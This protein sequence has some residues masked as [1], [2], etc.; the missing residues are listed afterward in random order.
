MYINLCVYTYIYKRE[1]FSSPPS[2]QSVTIRILYPYHPP[3]TIP[4]SRCPSSL[5]PLTTY[6][7]SAA[8]PTKSSSRRFGV[9]VSSPPLPQESFPSTP[10]CSSYFVCAHP[11]RSPP[12]KAPPTVTPP[13]LV[14][15]MLLF[16]VPLPTTRPTPQALSIDLHIYIYIHACM[17]ILY[18]YIL[19][20][21]VVSSRSHH[22]PPPPLPL[23]YQPHTHHCS[24]AAIYKP[25][26]RNLSTTLPLTTHT[27]LLPSY[28]QTRAH[29]YTHT[30]T[31][32]H[33]HIS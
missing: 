21:C 4:L 31:H 1:H 24:V 30:C 14:L 27:Q 33:A 28:H 11:L 13:G 25:P 3:S 17:Y 20:A 12:T 23:H 15:C 16:R 18:I 29:T 8:D 9:L 22:T 2:P 32:T 5:F 6:T 10:P 7:K 26:R 19:C